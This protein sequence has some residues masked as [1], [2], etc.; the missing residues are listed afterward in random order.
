MIVYA[1]AIMVLFLFVI[2]L[3]NLQV[4]MRTAPGSSRAQGFSAAAVRGAGGR[5][6]RAPVRTRPSAGDAQALAPAGYG[7]LASLATTLFSDYLIAFEVTSVLLLAAM[8]GAI[9]LAR[10]V[11]AAAAA[12][13][14]ERNRRDAKRSR[15]CTSASRCA[16]PC[17]GHSSA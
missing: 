13:R 9:A 6:V 1:G 11:V 17:I 16:E 4:E 3:L 2:W 15:R 10:R 14:R 7:S 12:S 8:V 5:A